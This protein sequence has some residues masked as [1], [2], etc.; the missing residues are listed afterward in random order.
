MGTKEAAHSTF[1]ASNR[2]GAA[3]VASAFSWVGGSGMRCHGPCC[4]GIFVRAAVF[5]TKIGREYVLT[6]DAGNRII[7][8]VRYIGG[9][10]GFDGDCEVR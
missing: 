8:V 1:I 2:T 5:L 9:R 10:K 7:R 3:A 4:R 6:R